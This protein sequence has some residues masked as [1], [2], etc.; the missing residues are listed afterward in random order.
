MTKLF[1][2][3]SFVIMFE[4]KVQNICKVATCELFKPTYSPSPVFTETND[5]ELWASRREQT[6]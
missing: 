3:A 1:C 4:F 2:F 6:K 5:Q